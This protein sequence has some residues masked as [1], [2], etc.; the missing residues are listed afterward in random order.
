[1]VATIFHSFPIAH[2][3]KKKMFVLRI[4]YYNEIKFCQF[5]K[6]FLFSTDIT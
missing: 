1:M 5:W 6:Y 3:S 2:Y 4:F